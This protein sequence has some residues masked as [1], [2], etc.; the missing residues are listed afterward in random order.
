MKNLKEKV[1]AQLNAPD[2]QAREYHLPGRCGALAAFRRLD[3]VESLCNTAKVAVLIEALAIL[4]AKTAG[5]G[6]GK[7]HRE[8][9][10]NAIEIT[11]RLA[12][13]NDVGYY[14]QAA[15]IAIENTNYSD[16][17]PAMCYTIRALEIINGQD[18]A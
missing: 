11:P 4:L 3:F 16:Y 13:S 14:I 10:D 18:I 1:F 2:F 5:A 6:S 9:F 17:I 12:R 8:I 15:Q 7:V